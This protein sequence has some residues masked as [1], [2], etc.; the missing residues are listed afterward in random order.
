M[1]L[2][3]KEDVGQK[4]FAVLPFAS[5]ILHHLSDDLPV[6]PVYT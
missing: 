2:H 3:L 4:A 5:N 6:F 1:D